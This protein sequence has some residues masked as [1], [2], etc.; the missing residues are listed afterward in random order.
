MKKLSLWTKI[1]SIIILLFILYP[2]AW[3]VYEVY[4][5]KSTLLYETGITFMF[6]FGLAGIS[7]LIWLLGVWIKSKRKQ[8]DISEANTNL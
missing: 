6:F 7:I 8:K 1:W 3:Y 5:Q 4:I 2:I